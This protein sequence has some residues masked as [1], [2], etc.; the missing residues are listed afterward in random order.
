MRMAPTLL[1][2]FL[3][4]LQVAAHMRR[5]GYFVVAALTR[6][7]DFEGRRK[8]EEADAL[9]EALSEV[10]QLTVVVP[11]AVLVR[12]SSELTV[13]DAS[14]IADTTLEFSMRAILWALGAPE[15]LIA[16][17]GG[18]GL[19]LQLRLVKCYAGSNWHVYEE[20][21]TWLVCK[22]QSLAERYAEEVCG[23]QKGEVLAVIVSS[24]TSAPP[25]PV[26][27]LSMFFSAQVF[28]SSM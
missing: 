18:W 9:V 6:P 21:Q 1:P 11:Q 28:F 26:R 20:D 15:L 22:Q 14:A 17:A 25:D 10:A 27:Q 24:Q 13:K 23:T 2:C 19:S 3:Q 7:F 5:Q 8:L 4:M 12:A 16:A